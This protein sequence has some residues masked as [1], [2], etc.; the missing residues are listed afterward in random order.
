MPS[1]IYMRVGRYA[2]A[3]KSNED[4]IRADEDYIAQCRAQGIYPMG[5]YPHNIH[6]LWSAAAMEGRSQAAIAAARKV[7]AGVTD[8]Q[9]DQLPLLAGFKLVPYYAL[10]R[11]GRWDEMLA[12][13]A[14]ADRFLYLKGTWHYGRGLALA[15]KGR[16]DEAEK[17]LAEVTRIA[18]DPALHFALF[19][20]NTASAIFAVAPE[21][22]AGEIAARRKDYDRA[23][24]HLE[25]AVRLEDSL[26]Y[27]E[28]PEWH[29]PTRQLLAAVLLEAGRAREAETVYWEDLVRNPENGWSLFGLW[30]ALTA[31]KR[32]A[33]AALVDARRARA[34][35]RA[36]VALTSSRF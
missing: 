24:P 19:S 9:M 2:D 30:Q 21:A 33:D 11:F 36:D 1:H 18:A 34:W 26:V 15:A 27:T 3:S 10:T 14:P 25:R 29:Y 35:A 17:E 16:F 7:A 23:I 32:D 12:E 6:F 13:P 31:Q 4:A 5:Y 22:L 28:P 8:Q 20:P